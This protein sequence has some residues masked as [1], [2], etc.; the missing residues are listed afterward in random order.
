MTIILGLNIEN[1][2]KMHFEQQQFARNS[3]E[4]DV[5]IIYL[6]FTKAFDKKPHLKLVKK[7]FG[8]MVSAE[9]YTVGSKN[10]RQTGHKYTAEN[11]LNAKSVVKQR[12]PGD[13]FPV[14]Q[15]GSTKGKQSTNARV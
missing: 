11:Q 15:R 9:K 10:C 1:E 13:E 12:H 2:A 5:D 6:H 4:K 7:Y 3:T 8:G 14:S